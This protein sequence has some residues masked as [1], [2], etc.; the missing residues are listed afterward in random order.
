MKRSVVVL[1]A[2]LSAT[3]GAQ[4]RLS[5]GGGTGVT[6]L[7]GR[8]GNFHVHVAMDYSLDTS[9]DVGLGIELQQFG[10]ID[11]PGAVAYPITLRSRYRI[12]TGAIE[13]YV[14]AELGLGLIDSKYIQHDVFAQDFFEFLALGPNTYRSK[15]WRPTL[16]LGFG[17]ETPLN[18][19]F[20][21]DV[22]ARFAYN[23]DGAKSRL[24]HLVGNGTTAVGYH[25]QDGS[26]WSYWRLT[27][28]VRTR[29]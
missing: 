23:P 28:A 24:T 29:L 19:T 16:G 18:E 26:A 4:I 22:A 1:L 11:G 25:V 7:E 12:G 2:L 15:E 3:S 14:Q 13:P 17:M 27:A 5:A 8:T 21:L 9:W 10:A 6:T 20:S